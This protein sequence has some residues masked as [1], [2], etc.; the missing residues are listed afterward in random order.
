[1]YEYRC[2]ECGATYEQLK[3]MSEADTNIE[4]PHCKSKKIERL[5]ST[6]AFGAP[7]TGGGWNSGGGCGSGGGGGFS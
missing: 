7:S 3:K 4:C 6:C 5:L 1:M 2:E